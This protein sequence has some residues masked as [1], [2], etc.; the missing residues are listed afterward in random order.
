MNDQERKEKFERIIDNY[1]QVSLHISRVPPKT[2]QEFKDFAGQ[3]FC[4]DF[5]MAFKHI[6]DSYK[7][8]QN[9]EVQTL[10]MQVNE[11]SQRVEALE[12]SNMNTNNKRTP[13]NILGIDRK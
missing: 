13:K 11:L 7:G 3:E 4:D 8:V 9:F 5:G 6:W 2:K 12:N 10:L 1:N